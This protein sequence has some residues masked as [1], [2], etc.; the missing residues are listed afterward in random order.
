[1]VQP[2]MSVCCQFLA[3]GGVDHPT[4]LYFLFVYILRALRDT[5]ASTG[6]AALKGTS[7]VFLL[8]RLYHWECFAG[9]AVLVT[10]ESRGPALRVGKAISHCCIRVFL[11]DVGS[12]MYTLFVMGMFFSPLARVL[13]R[14]RLQ[15]PFVTRLRLSLPGVS[16][17]NGLPT[18]VLP[19]RVGPR[20]FGMCGPFLPAHPGGTS[21]CQ[22]VSGTTLG[23]ARTVPSG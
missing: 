7:T 13:L 22:I 14:T 9:R 11:F 18:C 23:P 20:V 6:W 3:G 12:P 4:T 8:V 15:Q 16:F 21:H 1:M 2:G 10:H 17:G 5:V 19:W